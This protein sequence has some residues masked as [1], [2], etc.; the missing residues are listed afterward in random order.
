LLLALGIYA[1]NVAASTW[2]W[3][4][5]LNAQN[6]RL[7]RR[8]LFG[9]FLVANFFNNFLPSNIG[10][11]VIRIRDTARVAQS[12]TLA[13]TVILVDRGI[14]LMG[15]V[16]ISAL[17]ATMVAGLQGHTQSPIWPSWLWATFLL[18]AAV[19]APVVWSPEGFGKLLRPL[20]VL[21]PEWV[22]GRIQTL[23]SAL[24]RFRNRPGALVSCFAGALLVQALLVLF[25]LSVVYALRL[26]VNPWDLAVIVPLSFVIQ[27]LPVS[28]NGFGVREAT[29][30]FYFTRLGLPIES[31]VLLSLVATGLTMLFSLTGAA[32]YV[33]RRR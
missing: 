31:A 3:H 22:G 28:V 18:G 14:G 9:S 13:T 1:L 4:V 21:H 24:G 10:G 23:I 15:L 30:S 8:T 29:F 7:R 19:T 12:K 2:R 20:T 5:L 16:L 27:M 11:D 32:V 17:G 26:A 6:V 25:Y 33:S